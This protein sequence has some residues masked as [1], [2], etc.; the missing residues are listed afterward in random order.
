MLKLAFFK[1]LFKFIKIFILV[2]WAKFCEIF[3]RGL[4]E[5]SASW[6]SSAVENFTKFSPI[7]MW[8][9]HLLISSFAV[10]SP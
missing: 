1:N 4:F 8:Y 3:V 10:Q 6:P 5:A 9:L 2:D 7:L